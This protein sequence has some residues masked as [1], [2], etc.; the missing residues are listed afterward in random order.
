MISHSQPW[1][2]V[3]DT[4]SKNVSLGRRRS[5]GRNRQKST[6]IGLKGTVIDFRVL[7]IIYILQISHKLKIEKY[8]EAVLFGGYLVFL[9]L[10]P[11]LFWCHY[12][13]CRMPNDSKEAPITHS[14]LKWLCNV[15]LAM[16]C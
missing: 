3:A 11:A 5:L 6:E 4:H 10:A 2:P 14:E 9:N 16:K 13:S 15:F 12:T 7:R 1:S 8:Y